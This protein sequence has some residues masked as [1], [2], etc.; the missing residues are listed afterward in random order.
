[1][2]YTNIFEDPDEQDLIM[3]RKEQYNA[4]PWD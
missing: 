4:M 2:K 1:M 3:L